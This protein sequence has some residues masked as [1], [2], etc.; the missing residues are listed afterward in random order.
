MN[1]QL[2][3]LLVAVMIGAAALGFGVYQWF[4]PGDEQSAR[5]GEQTGNGLA[6]TLPEFS[7][8]DMNGRERAISEWAGDILVINFW[9]T[10][11][12]PCREEVPLLIE[13]QEDYADR[14]LTVLGIA[15]DQAE[16]VRQ[17]AEDFGINYPLLVGEQKTL[18]VMEAFGSG[19]MGLP[20]TFVVNRDG[21]IV[22]VHVGLIQPDEVEALLAPALGDAEQGQH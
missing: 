12:A 16:P 15:L 8:P 3:A 17:F 18:T 6:E 5:N 10:W 22:N 13:L 21:E 9:G 11:C 20:H 14:G 4:T 19:T 1:R 7:M 2:P